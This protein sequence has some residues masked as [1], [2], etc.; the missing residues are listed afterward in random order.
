MAGPLA[1]LTDEERALAMRLDA[2]VRRLA[3]DIG[4]RNLWQ[5]GALAA[6]AQ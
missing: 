4:E 5:P 2:H 6:A 1:P 3:G